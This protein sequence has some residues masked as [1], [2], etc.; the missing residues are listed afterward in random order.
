MSNKI[1]LISDDSDFFEFMKHKLELRTGDELFSFK[2]DEVPDKIS[3]LETAVLIINSEEA[4]Q[5]TLD[6]LGLFNTTP[7]IVTSYNEDEAFKKKCYRAGMTDFITVL[8]P[9]SEFRARMLPALNA[10]SVLEKNRQYRKLLVKNKIISP[11]KEVFTDYEKIIECALEE[12][13][14]NPRK[15]VLGAI[16]PDEKGKFM[17][18]PVQIETVIINNVRKN[19]ILMN[20]APSKYYL[21]MYDTDVKSAEKLWGKI[22]SKFKHN[23]YAGFTLITN[24]NSRQLIN[25]AL[26]KLHE[27]LNANDKGINYKTGLRTENQTNFKLFRKEFAQKLEQIVSPV[28]YSAQQKYSNKLYGVKIDSEYGDGY[29]T[30][31]IEGMHFKGVFSVLSPG[32]T[33]IVIDISIQIGQGEAETKRI[34]FEPEELEVGLLEDLLEQF[35]GEAAEY[36]KNIQEGK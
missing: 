20:Y 33:K 29:G 7:I 8:T 32:F 2:F 34:T 35:T 28:F 9:D 19:D 23:V 21:L 1:V 6:L 30:F 15:A 10:A 36:I 18:K 31:T 16:S 3:L 27:A 13:K 26:N 24:Q 5:K 25:N 22:S 12:L 11:T 17:L 14:E 4:H